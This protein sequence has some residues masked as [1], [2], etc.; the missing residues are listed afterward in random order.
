MSS[1]VIRRF[2]AALGVVAL[3]GA[4]LPAATVAAALSAPAL[5]SPEPGE[6]VGANPILKWDRVEGAIKY[7]VQ[8]STSPAFSP[9]LCCAAD[10]Y[11]L[12]STPATDL[13]LGTLYWRVA[14]IDAVGALGE[15]ADGSFEKTWGVAPSPIAPAD[16]AVLAFP[17]DPLLFTWQP[18]VGAKMYTLE[19]DDAEDFINPVGKCVQTKNTSCTLTEPLTVDQPFYWRVVGHSPAGINSQYSA[20][21]SFTVS[22]AG[23]PTLV[24]PL[25]NETVEDVVLD[26]HPI[27]G[28]AGYQVQVSPNGD[29]ANNK[30]VDRLVKGTRYSPPAT[31]DNGSYF[32]RVRAHDAKTIA[33]YGAWSAERQFTRGWPDRP[34]LLTPANGDLAVTMP[35]F[36]WS[37]VDHATKYRLDISHDINFSTKVSCVTNQTSYTPY[38]LPYFRFGDPPP[39]ECDLTGLDIGL[40][41]YWRVRAL[42]DPTRVNGLHSNTGASDVFSFRYLPQDT[43]VLTP[44]VSDPFDGLAPILSVPTITW[45]HAQGA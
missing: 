13:P 23:A 2:A 32:W 33:N 35:T 21:R 37:P 12:Q 4:S 31:L 39:R 27:V 29:W 11:S 15:F 30:S 19:V 25:E 10:T 40:I 14:A 1:Q 3:L 22:W 7:R 34:T 18:L 38:V 9:V 20:T 24:S 44:V 26:W 16:G 41:Y 28:A 6:T 42:D 36:S 8:V 43:T 17:D 5:V 45:T